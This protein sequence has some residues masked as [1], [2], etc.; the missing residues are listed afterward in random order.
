VNQQFILW[1]AV[2][3]LVLDSILFY[4]A[5]QIFQRETILS[6]WK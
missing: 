5:I 3:L 1:M 2:V 4:F 6:R